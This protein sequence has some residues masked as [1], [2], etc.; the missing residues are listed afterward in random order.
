M[1]W[2]KIFRQ[3]IYVPETHPL[4]GMPFHEREDEAHVSKVCQ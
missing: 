4:T 3:H 2:E 1:E